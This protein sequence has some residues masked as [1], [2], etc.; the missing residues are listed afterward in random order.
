MSKPPGGFELKRCQIPQGRMDA[1]RHVHTLPFLAQDKSL[2]YCIGLDDIDHRTGYFLNYKGTLEQTI[3]RCNTIN[4]GPDHDGVDFFVPEGTF[5]VAPA[6]GVLTHEFVNLDNNARVAR[7]ANVD[8]VA[9]SDYYL[10]LLFGH[11]SYPLVRDIPNPL[12]N[13]ETG[14]KIYRGQI[15]LLSGKTG[16]YSAPHL[17]FGLCGNLLPGGNITDEQPGFKCW[18]PYGIEFDSTSV[19]FPKENLNVT[20]EWTVFNNPVSP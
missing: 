17:H 1:F 5:I 8:I 6:P 18:D 16:T 20:S 15:I 13:D 11:H 12:V 4:K 2:I 19:G 10:V 9:K 3:G 14:S 7:L